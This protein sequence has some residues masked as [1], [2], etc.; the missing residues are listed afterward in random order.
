MAGAKE[1][2]AKVAAG[3]DRNRKIRRAGRNGRDVFL[4]VLRQAAQRDTAGEVPAS[5]LR[6]YEFLAMEL[7]CS[8]AEAREGVERAELYDLIEF[9]DDT[10]IAV[11]WDEEW[12]RRPLTP[13]ERQRRS[14]SKRHVT[15]SNVSKP[16]PCH[17]PKVTGHD[18]R[19]CHTGEERRGEEKRREEKEPAPPSSSPATGQLV[20]ESPPPPA[21]KSARTRQV[22]HPL[23]EDWTPKPDLVEEARQSGVNLAAEVAKMRDWAKAEG[24]RKLDWDATARNWIRRAA[25]RPTAR[26]PTPAQPAIRRP[27]PILSPRGTSQ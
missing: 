16:T 2:F 11:G 4:W 23:P 25:E 5:D 24:S 10:C 7:M 27:P 14:R 12:G 26:S 17:G 19:D 22:K 8:E 13:A 3:L 1:P 9:V 18:D 21:A 6:D 20:L 15:D